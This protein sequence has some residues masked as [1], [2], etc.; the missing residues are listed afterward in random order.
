M[1]TDSRRRRPHRV[2]ALIAAAAALVGAAPA[3]LAVPAA[4]GGSQGTSVLP[5]ADLPVP[6][7][8]RAV[9]PARV[10][11]TRRNGVRLA[12]GGRLRVV[13]AGAWGVPATGA[14]AVQ[15]H[16]TATG[17]SRAS[18]LTVHPSGVPVPGTSSVNYS[19]ARPV[20]NSVTVMLGADG[21]VVITNGGGAV[22]VIVDL[23]G[24]FAATPVASADGLHAIVPVR[25]FDSR[26]TGV[27]AQCSSY[28]APCSI[29]ARMRDFWGS[30]RS[31]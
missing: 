4:A 14:G 21:A 8:Y 23:L 3:S 1:D 2:L 5:T 16:V 17:A 9:P 26:T 7:S 12:A 27:K 20:A 13:L 28:L 15:L 6:G 24:W 18:H 31:L 11:D 29:H 10:A 19:V 25:R 22:H 30:V